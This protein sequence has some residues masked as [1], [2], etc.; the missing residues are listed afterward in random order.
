M[1]VHQLQTNYV[2]SYVQQNLFSGSNPYVYVGATTFHDN[3]TI[4]FTTPL[5]KE[6]NCITSTNEKSIQFDDVGGQLVVVLIVS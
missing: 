2:L 1:L 6:N 3:S 4:N 5:C